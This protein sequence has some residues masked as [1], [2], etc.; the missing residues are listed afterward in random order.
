[1]EKLIQW[2]SG[3]TEVGNVTLG[4]FVRDFSKAAKELE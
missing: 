1:M 3:E 2:G 4:D